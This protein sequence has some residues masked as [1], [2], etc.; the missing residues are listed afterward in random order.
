MNQVAITNT[1]AD[2]RYVG[3]LAIPAGETRLVDAALLPPDAPPEPVAPDAPAAADG[4]EDPDLWAARVLD[5]TVAE[6]VEILPD[7]DAEQLT[8]LGDAEAEG[9][10]RSTLLA[11]IAAALQP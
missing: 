7:L 8:R 4:E 2:I 11:A 3:G 10:N 5:G 9:R 1:G 6:I